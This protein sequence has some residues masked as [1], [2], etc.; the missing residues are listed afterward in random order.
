MDLAIRKYNFIQKLMEVD[1][2][3]FDGL[4][5]F[6]NSDNG[7]TSINI[8]QYNSELDEANSR[9]DSGEFYTS[10]EVEKLLLFAKKH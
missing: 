2:S 3:V 4:E 1:E 6:L 5:E 7:A 9:I 10:E 8:E